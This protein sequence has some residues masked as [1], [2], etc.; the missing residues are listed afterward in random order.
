MVWRAV[1][2]H[3]HSTI[4]KI[5]CNFAIIITNSQNFVSKLVRRSVCRTLNA[6]IG[7]YIIYVDYVLL[8]V[9]TKVYVGISETIGINKILLS[10]HTISSSFSRKLM[11][12]FFRSRKFV[13]LYSRLVEPGCNEG[14]REYHSNSISRRT[15]LLEAHRFHLQR[16][17]VRAGS[18]SNDRLAFK[19][20]YRVLFAV[21]ESTFSCVPVGFAQRTVHD[22][23]GKMS[24][25]IRGKH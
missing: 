7:I 6:S 19:L 3:L 21:N 13:S 25:Q 20:F 17:D 1:V 23:K 18:L 14:Q 16:A 22:S 2:C 8:L 10:T 4:I 11:P 24:E 15:I 9:D 12:T 5:P